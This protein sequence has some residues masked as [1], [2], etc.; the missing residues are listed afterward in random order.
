MEDIIEKINALRD[1]KPGLILTDDI[2]KQF[3]LD[4]MELLIQEIED[5]L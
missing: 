3:I 1:D 2:I 4:N 5:N